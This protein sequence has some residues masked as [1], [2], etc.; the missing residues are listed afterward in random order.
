[1]A[2]DK[3]DKFV[4]SGREDKQLQTAL[5]LG[6]TPD[7]YALLLQ[8]EELVPTREDI[9]VGR[10]YRAHKDGV[11]YEETEEGE[12][13]GLVHLVELRNRR[14][15][16]AMDKSQRA[17]GRGGSSVVRTGQLGQVPAPGEP[18][19]VV[20]KAESKVVQCTRCGTTFD[21]DLVEA[22]Q[23]AAGKRL[24]VHCANPKCGFMLDLKEL[25]PE[26]QPAPGP[27]PVADKSRKPKCYVP[28]SYGE[29]VSDLRSQDRQCGD[30]AWSG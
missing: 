22:K 20:L 14:W 12:Y 6:L 3:V 15:Q 27:E 11:P 13:E 26:L 4:K 18:E 17:M 7:E 16:A 1:M 5:S 9:E 28:G 21:I 8:G 30:C 19:P 25:L 29:C 24:F 2:G 23:A 10:R